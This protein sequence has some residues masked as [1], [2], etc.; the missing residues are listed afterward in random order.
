[1]AWIFYCG[2]VSEKSVALNTRYENKRLAI[3]TYV[4]IA[5]TKK[6]HQL[7]DGAISFIN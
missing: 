7:V 3:V 2:K 6:P 5:R 4:A 1:M